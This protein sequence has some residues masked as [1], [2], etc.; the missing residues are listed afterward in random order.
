MMSSPILSQ[1][2]DVLPSDPG[3][4][5]V[6]HEAYV[7]AV[8]AIAVERIAEQATRE[9]LLAAKLVYGTGDGRYRGICYYRAWR[10]GTE[11]DLIEVAATGEESPVQL[12]GTTV[13]ETAH[14]LA[15]PG[16]GHGAAWRTACRALGLAHA[17][18]AGQA[19]A[20]EHFAPDI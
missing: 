15:G 9:R 5:A 19:Y 1:D 6:T 14:V 2:S 20:P 18:A 7:H 10:N 3:I 13:H 11:H 8:R 16:A 17:E 4:L 12:A